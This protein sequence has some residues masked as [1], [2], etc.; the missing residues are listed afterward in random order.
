MT[1]QD[2]QPVRIDPRRVYFRPPSNFE[3]MTPEEQD[4]WLEEVATSLWEGRGR[5]GPEPTS[6][7]SSDPSI[8]DAGK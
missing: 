4:A 3:E 6:P 8:V 7:S 1:S 2:D 5:S